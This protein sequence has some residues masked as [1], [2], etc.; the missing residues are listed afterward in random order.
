[1][2]IILCALS[3]SG[4]NIQLNEY[5]YACDEL[6][7]S[8]SCFSFFSFLVLLTVSNSILQ[9]LVGIPSSPTLPPSLPPWI[10]AFYCCP[11]QSFL[12][13][14]VRLCSVSQQMFIY[15]A[16]PSFL[17]FNYF[18]SSLLMKHFVLSLCRQFPVD[19]LTSP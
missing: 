19:M 3:A 12:F 1:M 2:V 9:D 10:P 6:T 16:D 14:W 18:M 5:D 13:H 11:S 15:M 7:L 17:V 4:C 8:K